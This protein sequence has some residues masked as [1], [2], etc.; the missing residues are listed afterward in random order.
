MFYDIFHSYIPDKSH[1]QKSSTDRVDQQQSISSEPSAEQRVAPPP[2]T[3]GGGGGLGE[4][5]GHGLGLQ[6]A[7]GDEE[8][9]DGVGGAHAVGAAHRRHQ[10]TGHTGDKDSEKTSH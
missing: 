3:G 1:G 8:H 4:P 2:G 9:G 5:G 10:D 7:E 6:N